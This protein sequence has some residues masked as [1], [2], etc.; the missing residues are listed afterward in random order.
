MTPIALDNNNLFNNNNAI[1][2]AIVSYFINLIVYSNVV[3]ISI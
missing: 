2:T 1:T 3:S